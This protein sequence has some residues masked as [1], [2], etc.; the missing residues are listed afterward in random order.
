MNIPSHTPYDGSSKLFTI[1]LKPLD[2]RNWIEIDATFDFQLAEKRRIYAEYADKV[3]VAEEA[4]EDAQAEVL[5][6]LREHLPARFQERYRREGDRMTVVGHPELDGLEAQHL[7][8]LHKASLLVQED[9]IIMRRGEDGWRLAAGS[10]C[11]PSSWLL[12][13]KF[14]KPMSAIHEPVP[15]F[16]PGTRNA[17]LIDR[18]FDRLQIGQP[19]ERFNWSIQAGDA[20]YHPLSNV[21]RIDRATGRPIRFPDVEAAA[22][23]FIR[24]ERQTLRKLPATGDILF[25]IRIHLDPIG[26]LKTRPDREALAISF[27][28][29]LMAL[30]TEQLDYKGLTADRDR[31]VEALSEIAA[32]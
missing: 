28:G 16:G 10:L 17:G 19:V 20:L 26:L 7:P 6:L 5:A 23:A 2:L 13:E 1:G 31:L 25:T 9:L 18:M 14:G 22:R 27:A 8:P 3:F 15:G 32:T 4:T 29:Q 12:T 30:D 21:E 11:F 24:V